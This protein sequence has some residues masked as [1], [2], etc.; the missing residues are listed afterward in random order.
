MIHELKSFCGPPTAALLII[1]TTAAAPA[2]T[3]QP[4]LRALLST[5]LKFSASDLA[6]LED[7]TVVVHGLG[8]KATGEIAAVGAVRVHARRA[9]FVESYRDIVRFKRTC[10]P[11]R[12]TS[13]QHVHRVNHESHACA[14]GCA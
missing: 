10:H 12:R 14:D 8:A 9:T 3:V 6:D 4:D 2:S 1:A 5:E 11:Q 7:G 13:I